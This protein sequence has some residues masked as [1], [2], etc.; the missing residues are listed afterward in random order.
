VQKEIEYNT[1][2]NT[3][4]VHGFAESILLK[5]SC[6]L[7]QSTGLMPS[8][9]MYRILCIR[10]IVEFFKPIEAIISRGLR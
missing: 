5:W 3:N 1:K 2:R 6:F 9:S 7:K 8:P 4:N 10:M